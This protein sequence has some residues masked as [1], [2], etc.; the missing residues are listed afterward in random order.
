MPR[1]GESAH[2][3]PSREFQR[4][5]RKPQPPHSDAPQPQTQPG[6]S[7]LD[8]P[9]APLDRKDHTVAHID[10][11]RQRVWDFVS[12]SPLRSLWDFQ[13]TPFLIGRQTH[14]ALLQRR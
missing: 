7:A 12:A 4:Y 6:P 1:P 9:A 10:P 2:A 8:A 3:H 5:A 13:G 14:R 11:H